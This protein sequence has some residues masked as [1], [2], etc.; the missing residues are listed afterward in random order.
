MARDPFVLMPSVDVVVALVVHLSAS[1]YCLRSLRK[2]S[3]RFF[4]GLRSAMRDN[5][6]RAI[7]KWRG[8]T[9]HEGAGVA[10]AASPTTNEL[11]SGASA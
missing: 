8:G 5:N 10:L 2:N 4:R 11:A 6:L 3:R 7:G 9:E 1:G